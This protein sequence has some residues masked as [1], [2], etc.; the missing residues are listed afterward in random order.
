MLEMLHPSVSP[1]DSVKV[2]G[3]KETCIETA[4]IFSMA[5][6]GGIYAT[7]REG[8]DWVWVRVWVAVGFGLLTLASG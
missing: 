5:F 8:Q 4:S 1:M 2:M 6:W 3:R 7:C